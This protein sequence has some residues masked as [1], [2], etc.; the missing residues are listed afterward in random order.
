MKY[1]PDLKRRIE[2]CQLRKKHTIGKR[3]NIWKVTEM[4]TANRSRAGNWKS[5]TGL[6][7]PVVLQ[8]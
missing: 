4:I 7:R 2:F 5:I 8:L 1:K 6:F 3:N